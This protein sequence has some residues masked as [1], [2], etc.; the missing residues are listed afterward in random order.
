MT[1]IEAA[2]NTK[3]N[4]CSFLLNRCRVE[5]T[6]FKQFKFYTSLPPHA[7]KHMEL[8]CDHHFKHP[9]CLGRDANGNSVTKASG[10]YTRSMVFMIVACVDL[11]TG[12]KKT[13][14]QVSEHVHRAHATLHENH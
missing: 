4:G 10:V 6:H 3:F 1:E 11:P 9:L 8:K 12:L 2:V 14:S 7:T 13:L 5:G